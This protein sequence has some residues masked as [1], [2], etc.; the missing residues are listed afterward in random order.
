MSHLKYCHACGKEVD[1]RA[2]IC[3]GCGVRQDT[4]SRPIVGGNTTAPK[5]KSIALVLSIFL[6]MLGADRF[7]LGYVGE[8]FA[9]LFT[10]GGFYIWWIID[11]V[12]IATG[13]LKPKNGAFSGQ[14][15]AAPYS[16][17]ISNNNRPNRIAPRKPAGGKASVLNKFRTKQER[18]VLSN[19]TAWDQSVIDG[20][21]PETDDQSKNGIEKI[22]YCIHDLIWA[23]DRFVWTLSQS[24]SSDD[25]NEAIG[26]LQDVI[27]YL[28]EEYK[29]Q[30]EVV[31]NI[32]SSG[33][34]IKK[35][36]S[37]IQDYKRQLETEADQEMIDSLNSAMESNKHIVQQFK[38]CQTAIKKFLLKVDTATAKIR[39]LI[40]SSLSSK[41]STNKI[42][43]HDLDKISQEI[44]DQQRFYRESLEEIGLDLFQI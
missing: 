34:N 21:Q 4:T 44:K 36:V 39:S 20:Q 7:Y 2:E 8:G 9:K 18:E 3:I 10:V 6:G 42:L 14:E 5:E 33:F 37:K 32:S 31:S 27:T 11:I 12:L 1:P 25:D 40:L 38:Q 26:R 23:K 35:I 15:V 30:K 24:D 29:Y 16:P 43:I 41:S 13:Q 22:K 28:V 19:L 17:P